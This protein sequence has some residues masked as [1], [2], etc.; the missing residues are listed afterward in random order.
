V[1]NELSDEEMERINHS[2]GGNL[3]RRGQNIFYE[4]TRPSGLY[5]IN[6]GKVKIYKIDHTGKEQIVRLA[7]AG[8]ILGYRS[9]IGGELYSSFAA[10]LED[11]LI[12]FIP[13]NVFF[14][15]LHSNS[16]LSMKVMKLLSQD[17]KSAENRIANMAQKPVRERLAE[18]LLV[19]KEFY[20]LEEDEATLGVAL[21]RE[22][23]ANVVGTATETVIRLLSEFKQDKIID[24]KGR[25][26][27]I[28]DPILLV[29]TANIYD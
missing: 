27:K 9:L 26:I 7:K 23:L 12:C 13:K 10:P 21:T 11:S 15:L 16:N 28:L 14:S 22:D 2:K 18:T 24:L 17:L 5:C 20:G 8:D 4:G 1:F 6:S 19:L 29:K 25:K 3:Y